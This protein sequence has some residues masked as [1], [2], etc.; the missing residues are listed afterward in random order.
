MPNAQPVPL[1]R[2]SG[3][4]LATVTSA[5]LVTPKLRRIRLAC[6]DFAVSR[7]LAPAAWVRGYFPMD[8]A[9]RPAA[10]PPTSPDATF[11]PPG[12]ATPTPPASPAVGP[13][14]GGNT[15]LAG[16]AA[17]AYTICEF[18]PAA[19]AFALD[20]VLHGHGPAA[21]WGARAEPGYTIRLA[22]P[23][24]R[25]QVQPHHR[26]YLFAG[27]TT[28]LPAIREWLE[29]I[30]QPAEVAVHIWAPDQPEH[31]ALTTCA[32][33]SVASGEPS[34]PA[35]AESSAELTITW[36]YDGTPSM[37]DLAEAGQLAPEGWR[38]QD[39][40]TKFFAAGEASLVTRVRRALAAPGPI[41][42]GN[43]QATPYWRAG[44][45]GEVQGA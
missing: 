3:P 14:S 42:P 21:R 41:P 24:G 27:D 1:R 10:P 6:P 7:P 18:D 20:F 8:D 17:R 36:H 44:Q 32:E 28:A 9:A 22:G 26:R 40:D 29:V 11:S 39:R 23:M 31:Q 16:T 13:S 37:A 4:M 45:A 12:D 15:E 30:P 33:H 34:A 43:L 19:H 2:R 5:E 35:E 25:G 38:P